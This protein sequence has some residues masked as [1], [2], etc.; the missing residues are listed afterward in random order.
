MRLRFV[1]VVDRCGRLQ[2][3]QPEK[4]FSKERAIQQLLKII[5]G[6]TVKNQASFIAWDGKPVPW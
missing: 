3:V 6:A 4:L 5:D 2:N 1:V